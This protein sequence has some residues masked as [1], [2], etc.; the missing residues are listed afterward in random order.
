VLEWPKLKP[1]VERL[2]L[3]DPAAIGRRSLGSAGA[4]DALFKAYHAPANSDYYPIV[5]QRASTT[6][7]TQARVTE[8]NEVQASSMPLLEMLDGTFEPSSRRTDSYPWAATDVAA[9]QAWALRDMAMGLPAT[10]GQGIADGRMMAAR[11]VNLWTATCPASITFAELLPPLLMLAEDVTPNLSAEAASTMWKQVI[12]SPCAKR[13]ARGDRYWIELFA[14]VARRDPIWM[15]QYGLALLDMHR[16]VR[17][18]PTEYA[19]LAAL[20]GD[21]CSGQFARAGKLFELGTKEWV[22][23]QKHA[24]ELRYLFF[25]ANGRADAP[26]SGGACVTAARR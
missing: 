5:D 7:F 24:A 12:E 11:V 26:I 15:T 25:L 1:V 8:L 21:V 9:L 22:R 20:T 3:A 10:N 18:P 4:V 23:P 2:K 14:A 19:F 16:D 17:S 13:L 6:R